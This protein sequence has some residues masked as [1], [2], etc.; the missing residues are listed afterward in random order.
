MIGVGATGQAGIIK[1]AAYGS[2]GTVDT[3][4]NLIDEDVRQVQEKIVDPSLIQSR[5]IQKYYNGV[6]DVL[7]GF[8]MVVDPD[9]IGLLLFMA[10]GVEAS[11]ATPG[12][13]TNTRTHIFTPAGITTDLGSFT[14]E[15]E[16]K[17]ETGNCGFIYESCM[18]DSMTLS[19]TKG[20][21]LTA[22][23]DIVGQQYTENQ[24]VQS[25]SPSTLLPYTFH[26]GAITVSGA[27]VTYVNSF[28]MTY[29]NHLDAD[30][31][32]VLD[33]NAFRHHCNKTL[34][35]LTGTLECEWDTTS[36]ALRDAYLDNTVK[37]LDFAFTS[38]EAIESGY[39]Y[40]LS[41]SIPK[42]YILGDLPVLTGRDRIPFTVNFEAAYDSTNFMNFAQ[43]DARATKWSA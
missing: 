17:Y 10:L 30:G 13:A 8:N 18:V 5:N 11:P 19:A 34:G 38:T 3:F 32:H 1:E 4:I 15:I 29:N 20:S 23:F 33:G 37:S 36:D 7:G 21:L 41:S 26:F 43:R 12:G 35:S 39:Y 40:T 16:R 24:A 31:G 42:I 25:L 9:N 28:T 27:G 14:L 22:R 6:L 2:V